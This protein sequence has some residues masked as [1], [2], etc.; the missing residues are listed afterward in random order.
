MILAQADAK[1]LEGEDFASITPAW[2]R[3]WVFSVGLGRDGEES[4]PCMEKW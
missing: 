3:G 1:G 2:F 4:Y